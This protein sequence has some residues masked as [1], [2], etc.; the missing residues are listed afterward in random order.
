MVTCPTVVAHLIE[1]AGYNLVYPDNLSTLCCGM[2]FSSKG[3][4]EQGDR[5]LR[6]L[7]TALL[8]GLRRRKVSGSHGYRARA[9]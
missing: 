2:A 5:K 7:E 6:E 4:K 8:D 3:F 1:R 9:S